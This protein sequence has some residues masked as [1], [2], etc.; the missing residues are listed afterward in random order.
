MEQKNWSVVRRLVGYDRYASK[1]ALRHLNRLYD[2]LRLYINFFQPVMKLQHKTR[3]GA[4]VHKVYDNAQTPYQRVLES[5]VLTREQ[6]ETLSL[7]YQKL[8][9]VQLLSHIN[10]TLGQLWKLAEYPQ[11]KQASVTPIYDATRAGRRHYKG[12]WYSLSGGP[13]LGAPPAAPWDLTPRRC[14]AGRPTTP[15]PEGP[16]IGTKWRG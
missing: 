1:S 12:Y 2:Y 7:Q 13:R 15:T 5:K 9:P 4:K 16:E 8:N 3:H 14:P 6:R 11:H 10:Q